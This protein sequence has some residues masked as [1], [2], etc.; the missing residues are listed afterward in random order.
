MVFS[1]IGIYEFKCPSTLTKIYVEMISI[2]EL[3]KQHS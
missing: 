1:H 3:K 2:Q